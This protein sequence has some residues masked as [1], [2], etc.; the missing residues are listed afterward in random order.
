MTDSDTTTRSRKTAKP[1]ARKPGKVAASTT[2]AAKSRKATTG[3]A[4]SRAKASPA[5]TKTRART[6]SSGRPARLSRQ[7]VLE[8]SIELLDEYPYPMD[9]F[10]LA[11]VAEELDTVSMAL[12]NYFPSRDAL[13]AA[14][15]DHVCM[16]F[17][18]PKPKP[19]QTW[20]DTLNA[21][22]WT[23]KQHA[24]RNPVIFKVMGYDGHTS[25]G[26]LRITMTVSRT[27]YGQ[28]MRG[29][30][31][32]IAAWLFCLHAIALVHSEVSHSVFRSPISLSHLEELEP[33]EQDFMLMLRPYHTEISSDDAL[34][35]GF[36]QLI[37][38]L[39]LKLA[40]L[41]GKGRS[42]K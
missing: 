39:E 32:A 15:A 17:K 35:E 5:T 22:L 9:G 36:N 11:R 20:Q 21:W 1:A 25:A 30:E 19:S 6:S 37:R 2:T 33:D 23:F 34:Q 4:A 14:V 3:S 29:K 41:P 40:E 16:Q 28:G 12:Y 31:L 26:W 10:T 42:K 24:E 38:G 13:L 18:M 27:L 7:M 8:K